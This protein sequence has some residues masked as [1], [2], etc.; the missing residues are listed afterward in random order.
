[1][2]KIIKIV[3]V[4]SL[5]FVLTGCE[6][7]EFNVNNRLQRNKSNQACIDQGGVPL[8]IGGTNRMKD[9]QFNCID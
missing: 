6:E 4:L 2:K 8:F 5:V 7:S 1:M 3:F 9:C